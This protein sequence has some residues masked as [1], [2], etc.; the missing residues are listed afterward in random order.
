MVRDSGPTQKNLF[1]NKNKSAALVLLHDSSFIQDPESRETVRIATPCYF[2][3]SQPIRCWGC[4]G[5]VG[6]EVESLFRTL[7]LQR[8]SSRPEFFQLVVHQ[9]QQGVLL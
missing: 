5:V 7:K 2:S 4:A 3:R 1:M 9:P 6:V 8:E